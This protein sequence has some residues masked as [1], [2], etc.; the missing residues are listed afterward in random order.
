MLKKAHDQTS[1]VFDGIPT[2]SNQLRTAQ[3]RCG[4]IAVQTSEVFFATPAFLPFFLFSLSV[5]PQ[6]RVLPWLQG[7]GVVLSWAPFR[8]TIPMLLD[9]SHGYPY[10]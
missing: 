1:E 10:E 3:I 8:A 2:G 9:E 5:L 4:A 6:M 7:Q